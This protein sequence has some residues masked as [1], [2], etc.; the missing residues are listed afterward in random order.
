M[1]LNNFTIKAQEAVQ[2]AQE[3]ALGQQ[4]PSIETAHLM[5]GLLSEDENVTPYLLKKMEVN[6]PRLTQQVDDILA[7]LPRVSGGQVYLSNDA[8]QALVYASQRAQ[9]MN[10][11]FVSV[12]HLLLGLLTGRD[13]ISQTLKDA[14]VSEKALLAAIADLRKGSKVTSQNQEQTMNAL[15]KYA[16]N[17]NQLAQAGKLDPVIG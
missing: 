8:N 9:K 11:E 1:N 6:V 3:I 4:H 13:R 15:G 12:E 10:D 16:K 5:K 7:T 2:K 17:L 14:G